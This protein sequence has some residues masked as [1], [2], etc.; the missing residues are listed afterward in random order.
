MDHLSH[1]PQISS[2]QTSS[3]ILNQ[4]FISNTKQELSE[5]EIRHCQEKFK[6]TRKKL[7]IPLLLGGTEADK[8]FVW[9]ELIRHYNPH[10]M[11]QFKFLDCLILTSP[12]KS[13]KI[14]FT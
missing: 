5:K 8:F 6:I 7:Q 14:T 9:W 11:L 4:L 10:Q 1:Y 12:N 3:T 13:V 2:Q